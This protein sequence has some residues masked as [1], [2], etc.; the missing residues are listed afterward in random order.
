MFQGILELLAMV[1]TPERFF[2]HTQTEATTG[3]N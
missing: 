1:T 2:P 3:Q